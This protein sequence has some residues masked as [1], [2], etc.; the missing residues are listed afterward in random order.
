VLGE[1]IAH[2]APV[3]I[4]AQV[5]E[6]HRGNRPERRRRAQHAGKLDQRID[7]TPNAQ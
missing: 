6:N 4:A 1:K 2:R 7:F 3:R 5:F